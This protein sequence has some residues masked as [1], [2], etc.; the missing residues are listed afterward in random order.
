[1]VELAL[2]APD[3]GEQVPQLA[4]EDRAALPAEPGLLTGLTI[5]LHAGVLLSDAARRRLGEESSGR[6]PCLRR[7]AQRVHAPRTLGG[8]DPAHLR[9]D[10]RWQYVDIC[11]ALPANRLDPGNRAA[12]GP[13]TLRCVLLDQQGGGLGG[14]GGGTGFE[15][16]GLLERRPHATDNIYGHYIFVN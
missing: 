12:V 8:P 7:S 6:V 1:V 9:E 10:A 5:L 2:E 14:T 11:P 13:P 16:D 4:P 3:R 15:G